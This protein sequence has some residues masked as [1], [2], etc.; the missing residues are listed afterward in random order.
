M[1][2]SADLDHVADKARWQ[3]EEPRLRQALLEAQFALGAHKQFAVVVVIGGVEG[4][5][6]SETVHLLNEWMDPRHIETRAFADPSDE[7]RERPWMW[8]FWRA[9]PPRGKIGLLFGSWYTDP[10][11]AHVLGGSSRAKLD[12]ALADIQRHER[13]LVDEGVLLLKFW[14]HLSKAQQ[15]ARLRK[16]EKDPDTRW[17]VT[18]EDWRRFKRYDEFRDTSSHALRIT[19]TAHAPW[20]VVPGADP[21]YR[22]LAVGKA[23]LAALQARN[24][25]AAKPKPAAAPA[26]PLPD[27]EQVKLLASLDLK[28]KLAKPKYEK[29]LERL[30]GELNLLSRSK[31]FRKRGLIALFE[32]WDAAGKGSAIRRVTA[33]LDARYYKVVPVAAPTDEERA[34]PYLWRFWRHVPRNGQATIFDRSWYGRVLVERV[35]GFCSPADWQRAYAEINDFEAELAKGGVVLAKFWLHLSPEEQPRRFKARENTP[36]KRF[37][38]T[39]EDWRNRKQWPA[40]ERAVCDMVDRCSTEVAPWTLVEAEDKY[41]ARIRILETLVERLEKAL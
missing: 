12:S 15:K 41:F 1:F 31:K 28:R 23:L 3:R 18:A 4:A 21:R 35:E 5:G 10:I 38:I 13:M 34:Q 37:K 40:Y 14:F 6:K 7:E 30:Q 9:L 11:L 32:G 39:A 33:A 24:Q 8:R 20:I 27:V 19:G 36:F 16:L 22:S 29:Q 17:R 25:A 26:A 2:D